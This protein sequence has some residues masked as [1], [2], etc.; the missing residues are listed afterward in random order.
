MAGATQMTTTTTPPPGITAKM[1]KTPSV[2]DGVRAGM[3]VIQTI[4]TMQTTMFGQTT[5]TRTTLG[6]N[7]L[8]T[9]ATITIP[10]SILLLI[11]TTRHR[12][13]GMA[14]TLKNQKHKEI[15]M[16]TTLRTP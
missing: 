4:P 2:V 10:G 9:M 12:A 1:Q 14:I 3:S 5:E 6:A 8:Q 7:S 16:A 13:A 15:G 11:I